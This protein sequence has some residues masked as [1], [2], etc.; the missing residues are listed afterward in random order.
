MSEEKKQQFG[1][2]TDP[3]A[4]AWLQ[5]NYAPLPKEADNQAAREPFTQE[6]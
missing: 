5:R 6:Q 2:V 1:G 3:D 4:I